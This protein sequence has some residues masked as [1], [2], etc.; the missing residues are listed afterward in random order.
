MKHF[1]YISIGSN[2]GD[3]VHNCENAILQ[4]SNFS[5]LIKHSSFYETES[6]GYD[7]VNLYINCVVKIS[8]QLN[9]E[10][11]L[12]QLKLIEKTL[13]RSHKK[14]GNLYESRIID[15]DILFFDN[16]I[17]TK[18]FNIDSTTDLPKDDFICFSTLYNSKSDFLELCKL[19]ISS[20][21]GLI[22]NIFVRAA[23]IKKFFFKTTPPYIIF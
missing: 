10:T 22:F 7:D 8:T 15:L 17:L 14:N 19:K 3:R 13:G 12:S 11:L 16:L 4:L 6:W 23:G 18:Y 1:A 21:S 5:E 2:L 9:P 20:F